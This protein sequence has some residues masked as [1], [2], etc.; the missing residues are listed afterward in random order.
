M[1]HRRIESL[2]TDVYMLRANTPDATG[3]PTVPT[4]QFIYLVRATA[5]ARIHPLWEEGLGAGSADIERF[6]TLIADRLLDPAIP[7]TR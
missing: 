6:V 2:D 1:E 3:E 4:D 5:A 7:S